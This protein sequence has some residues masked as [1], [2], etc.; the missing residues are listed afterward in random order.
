MRGAD[1]QEAYLKVSLQPVFEFVP[2][3]TDPKWAPRLD[4]PVASA[5]ANAKP[6]S[7]I[8]A[9]GFGMSAA[10]E[11]AGHGKGLETANTWA[12]ASEASASSFVQKQACLLVCS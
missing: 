3:G 7:A 4:S 5:S 6:S 8:G 11:G 12:R 1:N 2:K 9:R 10:G